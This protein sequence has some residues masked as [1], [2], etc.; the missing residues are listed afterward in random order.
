MTTFEANKAIEDIQDAI[1]GA[2]NSTDRQGRVH[3]VSAH[4][5]LS[6]AKRQIAKARKR[7]L[8]SEE[9]PPPEPPISVEE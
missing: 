8:G 6:R 1:S 2:L 7:H 5:L 3:L 9:T 4:G